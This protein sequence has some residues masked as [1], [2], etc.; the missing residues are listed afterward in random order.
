MTQKRHDLVNDLWSSYLTSWDK[1]LV[2][3]GNAFLGVGTS[4]TLV[5]DN[6]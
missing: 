6:F 4:K 3:C 1:V 2:R 5:E